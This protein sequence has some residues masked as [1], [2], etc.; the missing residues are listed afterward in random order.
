MRID[1]NSKIYENVIYIREKNNFYFIEFIRINAPEMLAY[2]DEENYIIARGGRGYPAWIWTADGIG[3]TKMREVSEIISECYLTEGQKSKFTAKKEFY[4]YLKQEK[5]PYLNQEDYFEMGTLECKEVKAPKK[6]DGSI[7]RPKNGELNV[8]AKYLFKSN[9]EMNRGELVSEEKAYEDVKTML[10]T[11]TLFIW[12]NIAGKIVSMLNYQIAGKQVKLGHV[13][14][15]QEERCK[16]Y[17][18][19]LVYYV[20]KHFLEQQLE[21]LLYTDYHYKA[22]NKAYQNAGYVDTGILI[23]FTCFR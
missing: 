21:P 6:C 9:Q 15:P 19:N 3:E 4:D 23:N 13:Y 14:T 11:E 2:S 12:R 1:K 8:L 5:Y 7:D 22:S 10:E 16:G 17:A 18:A 20:T